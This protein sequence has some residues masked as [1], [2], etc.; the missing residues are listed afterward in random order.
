M[1]W[2]A[3]ALS[4]GLFSR[5]GSQT[6]FG[7]TTPVPSFPR[8]SRSRGFSFLFQ[9]SHPDHIRNMASA[10][11]AQGRHDESPGLLREPCGHRDPGT[12]PENLAKARRTVNDHRALVPMRRQTSPDLGAFIDGVSMVTKNRPGKNFLQRE[13]V[14]FPTGSLSWR[15]SSPSGARD[16]RPHRN[17]RSGAESSGLLDADSALLPSRAGRRRPSPAVALGSHPCS[18]TVRWAAHVPGR[19]R[20]PVEQQRCRAGAQATRGAA[21]DLGRLLRGTRRRLPAAAGH[22][23][24]LPVPG[25]VLPQVPHVRRSGHRRVPGGQAVA[26]LEAGG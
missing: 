17:G 13:P 5:S 8:V 21:Q 3:Q 25:E 23:P 26:D 1:S 15:P 2:P 11:V 9:A 22:G 10:Q 24:D 19:G 6:D 14:G 16:M 20:H 12:G 7:I 4:G 18:S